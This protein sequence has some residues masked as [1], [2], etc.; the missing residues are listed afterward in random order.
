MNVISVSKCAAGVQQFSSQKIILLIHCCGPNHQIQIRF[1]HSEQ[2]FCLIKWVTHTIKG[3]NSYANP[4]A[5]FSPWLMSC[6]D[7]HI[8]RSSFTRNTGRSEVTL[9]GIS[10]LCCMVLPMNLPTVHPT[11]SATLAE[12]DKCSIFSREENCPFFS[13]PSHRLIQNAQQTE[14]LLYFFPR[15]FKTASDNPYQ[16]FLIVQSI[17]LYSFDDV[18]LTCG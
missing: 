3:N 15:C 8:V 11:F 5:C 6:A 13:F 9:Q 16:F 4:P 17:R 10:C 12:R 14:L 1:P 18:H 2:I 7:K